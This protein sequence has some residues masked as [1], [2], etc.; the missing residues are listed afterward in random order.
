MANESNHDPINT[1]PLAEVCRR[2]GIP[3][4]T[5]DA[6][7]AADVHDETPGRRF[8]RPCING[9]NAK[10]QRWRVKKI[11]AWMETEEAKV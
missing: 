9:A 6:W 11:V 7:L 10:T 2:T 8:P 4:G 3:R 5:I 1:I